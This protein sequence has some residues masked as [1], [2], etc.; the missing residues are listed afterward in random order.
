MEVAYWPCA[1]VNSRDLNHLKTAL[2]AT[3]VLFQA[4]ELILSSEE[5]F[6]VGLSLSLIFLQNEITDLTEKRFLYCH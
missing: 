1:L 4:P 6:P 3:V 5:S 2:E